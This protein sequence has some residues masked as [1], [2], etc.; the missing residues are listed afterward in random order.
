MRA[1]REEGHIASGLGQSGPECS[2]D[3]AGADHR[4]PHRVCRHVV[5]RL[6]AGATIP[7]FA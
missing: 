6:G 4:D 3:A 2:T 7:N 1:T 5:L